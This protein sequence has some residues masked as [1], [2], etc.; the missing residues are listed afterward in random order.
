MFKNGCYEY[1]ISFTYFFINQKNCEIET[2][3]DS[4]EGGH[5]FLHPT[6]DSPNVYWIK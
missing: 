2:A 5:F 3:A 4:K 6:T 1:G